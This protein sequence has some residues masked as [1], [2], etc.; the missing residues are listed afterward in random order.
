MRTWRIPRDL[1]GVEAAGADEYFKD[2]SGAARSQQ[3][4]KGGIRGLPLKSSLREKE[5]ASFPLGFAGMGGMSAGL[6]WP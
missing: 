5:G 2:F 3:S 4:R 1:G 6:P